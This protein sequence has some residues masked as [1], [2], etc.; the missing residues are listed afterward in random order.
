MFFSEPFAKLQN[1]IRKR[2]FKLVD[3]R[4]KVGNSHQLTQKNL[5]I[6]PSKLGFGYVGLLIVVWLIGT[7]YQNNL[8]LALVFILMSVF[9]LAISHTF[10][11]IV[12]LRI[13]FVK[14]I[15]VYAGD[16]A[17]FVFNVSNPSNKYRDAIELKW[18]D[19]ATKI[20]IDIPPSDSVTVSIPHA[21]SRRGYLVP[22]RLL[23][24]SY[25]PFG[26]F[27]CWTWVRWDIQSLV[28]PRPVEVLRS[29]STV[30]D[31][32][33]DGAHPTRG[34]DDYSGLHE[35]RPGD[36]IKHIAWKSYAREQGLYT[37]EFSQN[38]SKE[39]WLD[40][41]TA[42]G[43]NLEHKLSGLTYWANRYVS[44]DEY[45]GLRLAGEVIQP[46]KGEAHK[47]LIL[48]KLASFGLAPLTE[49]K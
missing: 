14:M 9:F 10:V 44:E 48:Q 31:E 16:E 40:L 18:Q 21:T 5:Y 32:E 49:D 3:R 30:T 43:H 22:Q 26:L 12:S 2:F 29:E 27:R 17:F 45:F 1:P 6:F 47:H 34:G 24:Q 41:D 39:L 15:P 42:H 46:E 35:Y 13:Q 4:N 20:V 36:Q 38:V 23:I 28:Y 8:V 33:G 25:Y 19:E 7:N 11:N 37:K